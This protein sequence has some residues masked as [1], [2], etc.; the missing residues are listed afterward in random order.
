MTSTKKSNPNQQKPLPKNEFKRLLKLVEIEELLAVKGYRRIAGVDEAGRGPLA[1]PV[2]AAACVFKSQQFFSGINDSKL[3]TPLRRRT[4]YQ[5]LINH[6]ELDYG[7]GIIE[8]SVIDE[9]NVLQATLRAMEKAVQALPKRPDYLLVDGNVALQMEA[10]PAEKVIHGDQ[11]SQVIAAASIIAKEVRDEWMLQ[12]HEHYPE[13]GFK[14]HKGYGTAKHL[15]AL[16]TY[17]PCPIHRKTFAPVA[18]QLT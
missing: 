17:G 3:L 13:Y 18:K 14:E 2:V 4:L 15:E 16:T 9:I 10:I 8:A 1:G 6:P 7:I 5:E 11:R 12:I